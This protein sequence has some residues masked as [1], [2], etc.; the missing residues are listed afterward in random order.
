LIWEWDNVESDGNANDYN[1]K[2]D[3]VVLG[4]DKMLA[5]GHS[6]GFMYAYSDGRL[7]TYLAEARCDDFNLGVYHSKNFRNN[8]VE[9]K[10]Y[11]GMGMQKYTM[12]R[13]MEI[14]LAGFCE[15]GDIPDHTHNN[16]THSGSVWTDFGGYT[17]SSSTELARPFYFGRH[18]HFVVRPYGAMDIH[19]VW[20]GSASETGDLFEWDPDTNERGD[21]INHLVTLDYAR[22]PDIRAFGRYG[23]SV[24]WDGPN[25]YIRGGMSHSYLLG[26]RP[27]TS[28]TNQFQFDE[29]LTKPFNIRGVSEGFSVI[30]ST[31]GAG[32]YFG[33]YRSGTVWI[34]YTG[35]SG[36][37]SAS[38]SLQVGVQKRF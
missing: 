11:L 21:D 15:D 30:S 29:D 34:D 7:N 26:G 6:V 37:R 12:K 3:G 9:W 31:C 20:Q 32:Y 22:A 2:R 18:G 35:S 33:N 1:I 38:H 25:G 14:E 23:V 10:N 28:V 36:V 8:R 16:D 13:A 27:Y 5:G 17:F 19:G 4:G 24:R